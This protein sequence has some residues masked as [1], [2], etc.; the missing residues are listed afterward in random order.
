MTALEIG[1]LNRD[2]LI[3]PFHPLAIHL[4]PSILQTSLD[5]FAGRFEKADDI[6]KED[7][8]LAAKGFVGNIVQGDIGAKCPVQV[9]EEVGF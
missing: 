7:V 3:V 6:I 5:P 8:R 1:N 2:T 9:V 4:E